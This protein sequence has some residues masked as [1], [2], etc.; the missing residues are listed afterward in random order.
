[1]RLDQGQIEVV[2]EAMAEVLR[3]KTPAERIRIGFGLWT[4]ARKM[5]RS[6]LKN[7]YPEWDD[8]RIDQELA[9]RLSHGAG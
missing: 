2:E 7:T 1:M 6:H 8:Q 9:R 4:S 3:Q 5:L